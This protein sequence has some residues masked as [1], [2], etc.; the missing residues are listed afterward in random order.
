[1]QVVGG[2][3]ASVTDRRR[4]RPTGAVP[5]RPTGVRENTLDAFARARRA[6]C[7]RGRARRPADRRRRPGRPPRP[8]GRR[9]WAPIHE[10]AVGR[11]AR[12]RPAAGRRPRGLRRVSTVNI[13][14]KNLPGEPGF[15]PDE[16]WPGTVAEL[17]VAGRPRLDRW[18][19]RRSG[20]ARLDAVR[21]AAPA[22]PPGCWWPPG[23]TRRRRGGG[24]RARAAPPS[25]P[26]SR[27]STRR[28]WTPAHAA[29]LAVAAWTVD[30]RAT[31]SQR[32]PAPGWTR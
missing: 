32:W 20:P 8:G 24:R 14:I 7:R 6:G 22:W 19:S 3:S 15:D 16:L 28:W 17:V 27:W 31:W 2:G 12:L 5:T 11:T 21:Q 26:T 30:D 4:S 18:S 1:M 10:L 23:S 9:A 25:T 29:G 13:E